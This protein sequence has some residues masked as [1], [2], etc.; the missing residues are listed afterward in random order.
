MGVTECSDGFLLSEVPLGR[1][2]LDLNRIFHHC[3]NED[4]KVQFCLEMITRDLLEIH[5][6][7]QDCWATFRGVEPRQL[8]RALQ[9]V[10]ANRSDNPLPKI[11]NRPSNSQLAN[12][13]YNIRLCLKHAEKRLGLTG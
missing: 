9:M 12:E 6:L 5:C 1:G 4:P 7:T 13:E 8:A 3:E 10:W 2:F 11:S